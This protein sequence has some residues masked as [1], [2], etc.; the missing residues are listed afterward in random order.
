MRDDETE[1]TGEE[2]RPE[3]VEVCCVEHAVIQCSGR[4]AHG[5]SAAMVVK[6]G[7]LQRLE[8]GFLTPLLSQ[9]S[10]HGARDLRCALVLYEMT[11]AGQ[12][13]N[14]ELTLDPMPHVVETFRQCIRILQPVD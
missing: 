8:S 13:Q 4:E 7:A 2:F 3:F 14:R 9:P 11:R 5:P 10:A 12:G 1:K 6:S